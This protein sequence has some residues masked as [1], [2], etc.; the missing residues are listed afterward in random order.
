MMCWRRASSRLPSGNGLSSAATSGSAM[1]ASR[2]RARSRGLALRRATRAKMRSTSPICFIGTLS[3]SNNLLSISSCT[4]CCRACTCCWQR[5]GRFNQRRSWRAPI[6]VSVESN[7]LASVLSAVPERLMS[8]SRLRRLA[9]S[10]TTAS[11]RCSISNALT[12]GSA[13]RCVSRA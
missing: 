2:S 8:I 7:T 4:A 6:A 12:W 11:S 3:S 1:S 10:I 13:A 9:A 5:S